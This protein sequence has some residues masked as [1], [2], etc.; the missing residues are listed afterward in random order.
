MITARSAHIGCTV[1]CSAPANHSHQNRKLRKPNRPMIK[2]LFTETK[3]QPQSI[4]WGKE[5]YV[6]T[7]LHA[8]II[9][10]LPAQ[11]P[12]KKHRVGYV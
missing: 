6:Q 7:A 8:H 9:N 12:F 4:N 10:T 11:N 3:K 5:T 1:F 2:Q